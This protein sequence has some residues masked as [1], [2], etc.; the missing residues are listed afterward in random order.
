MVARDAE[1]SG[2]IAICVQYTQCVTST[3]PDQRRELTVVGKF[4]KELDSRN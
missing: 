2:T 4:K 1:F 3:Q